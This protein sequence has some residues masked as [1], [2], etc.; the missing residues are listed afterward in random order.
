MKTESKV[1][2]RDEED[3]HHDGVAH[4]VGQICPPVNALF[5]M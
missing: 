4:E 5:L 1:D 3:N 2:N